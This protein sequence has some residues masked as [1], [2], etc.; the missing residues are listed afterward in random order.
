[1]K[2]KVVTVLRYRNRGDMLAGSEIR[3]RGKWLEA[4]GFKPGDRI[5]VLAGEGRLVIENHGPRNVVQDMVEVA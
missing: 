5:T 3:L 4:A 1:M 2:T